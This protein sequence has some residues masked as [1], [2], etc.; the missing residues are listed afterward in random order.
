MR[1]S[2]LLMIV[3][4]A[5]LPGAA[6]S[7]PH[8]VT[9]GK[10]TSVKLFLG[11]SED[12]T[13]DIAVRPLYVDTKLKEFTT[14]D[15]HEV[16]DRQFVVR[17]A[18]RINDTLPDDARRSPKWLW[19]RGGWLL[20]D[21]ASG[22]LSLLRLPD[23]DPFYSEVSWYRDYAAYCG[24]SSSGERIMAVVAEIGAKKPVFRK[25]LGNVSMGDAPDSNCPAPRWQRQ[26]ARVTFVPKAGE[27]FTENVSGR[28][29]DEAPENDS[30]EQ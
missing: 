11:P 18:Y 22:K 12:Q 20:V 27:K 7:K 15:T 19:Q 29:A 17:R 9:L 2:P 3:L 14:G 8:T 1:F 16:T 13:V 28:F 26:P 4:L 5:A 24:V 30:D 23:F 10:P 6:A 25:E 21:R